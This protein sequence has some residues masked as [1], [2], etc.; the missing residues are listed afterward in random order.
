[1]RKLAIVLADPDTG[2]GVP[3]VARFIRRAA[4]ASGRYR[5][6][7]FSLATSSRDVAS[8]RI[9]DPRT[10]LRG[11]T[12]GHRH[13]DGENHIH[14]GA[15]FGEIELARYMR[16]SSLSAALSAYDVV[17]V[18]AGGAAMANVALDC[19]APVSLQVATRVRLERRLRDKRPGGLTS[20]WRRGMTAAIDRLEQRVLQRVDAVQVENP[21]MLDFVQRITNGRKVDV[22]YAPP[23]V[24]TTRF[25]P[26]PQCAGAA[27]AQYVLCVGRLDDPRKNVQLLLD[28]Y[29]LLPIALRRGVRLTLAG[30]T[31]PDRAFWARVDELDLRRDVH[32]VARPSLTQ[33]ITLYQGAAAFALSSD[34][35]GLGLVLL[36][37]MACGAVPVATRCGGPDGVL[38]DG[39][40]G[41]LVDVGD[42]SAMADRLRVLLTDH[43]QR[44]MMARRARAKV[45]QHY[46]AKRAGEEYVRIWDTLLE[47]RV[48]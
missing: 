30:A 38:S 35:E 26:R 22:R 9:G 33:L 28:S 19:G 37:A 23:G 42:A 17:Q 20:C 47:A 1:M 41:F 32:Y 18:V 2:G 16:R 44:C 31:P 21:G 34:E 11:P 13:W 39:E 8:R 5:V 29:A 24:D 3:V 36:E 46:D 48:N 7:I 45:V 25:V 43:K 10:W 15:D 14:F 12:T 6:A 27:E 4:E 40:D